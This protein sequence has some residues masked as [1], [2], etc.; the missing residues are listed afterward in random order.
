MTTPQTNEELRE[1][2]KELFNSHMYHLINQDQKIDLIM[3]IIEPIIK[4]RDELKDLAGLALE[5]AFNGRRKN[6]Q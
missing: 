1:K 5:H 6:E 2:I 4:E 3:S